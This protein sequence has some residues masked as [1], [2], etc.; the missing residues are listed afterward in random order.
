MV[1]ENVIVGCGI[2]GIM[3]AAMI[4]K[5]TDNFVILEKTNCIGGV[6]E[7]FSKDETCLQH[8]SCLYLLDSFFYVPGESVSTRYADKKF[9]CERLEKFIRYY[10]LEQHIIFSANVENFSESNN[11]VNIRYNV[12]GEQ[13]K[14]V[15]ENLIICTGNLCIPRHKISES[16]KIVRYANIKNYKE[17]FADKKSVIVVGSGASGVEV[18]VHAL[19]NGLQ[20]VVML[21][22]DHLGFYFNG[23][24]TEYMYTL[25]HILPKETANHLFIKLQY[26]IA[27]CKGCRL[28]GYIGNNC[29]HIY[30][31]SSHIIDAYNQGHV[32]FLKNEGLSQKKML[33]HCDVIVE[34]VGFD[35]SLKQFNLEAKDLYNLNTR[36]PAYRKVF[37]VGLTKPN[38]GTVAYTSYIL[39]RNIMEVIE[40]NMY[41]IKSNVDDALFTPRLY[42]RYFH[43]M[44]LS[45]KPFVDIICFWIHSMIIKI[46]DFIKR[47]SCKLFIN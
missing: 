22:K 35:N 33:K 24:I 15:S 7:T 18:C 1:Y 40:R 23:I 2:S 29:N 42:L 34:T 43:A 46:L 4:K 39:L 21:Y 28:P 5:K 31:F 14:I 41:D 44:G 3:A 47:I 38:T 11:K 8:N 17:F 16:D 36:H 10:Q 19:E 37:F 6:W 13:F 25:L 32:T 26:V 12:N 27:W 20:D 9:I 45:M 30:P